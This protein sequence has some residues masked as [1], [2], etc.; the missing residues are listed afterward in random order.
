[1]HTEASSE[2]REAVVRSVTHHQ[3]LNHVAFVSMSRIVWGDEKINI[4]SEIQ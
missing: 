4:F 2:Q 1:M 3:T